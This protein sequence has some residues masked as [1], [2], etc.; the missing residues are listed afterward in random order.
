MTF[1]RVIDKGEADSDGARQDGKATLG[2]LD[3]SFLFAYAVGMFFSGSVADRSNLRTYLTFSM[4]G[5]PLC[6]RVRV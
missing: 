4:L 2:L 3:T 6:V 1:V 5:R